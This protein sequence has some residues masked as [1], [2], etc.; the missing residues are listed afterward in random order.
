MPLMPEH[1]EPPAGLRNRTPRF[2]DP[3]VVRV[4]WP[5]ETELTLTQAGSRLGLKEPLDDLL[6]DW[7]ALRAL[8]S[9]PAPIIGVMGLLN[10]GKSSLVKQF[11]SPEGR[12]RVLCGTGSHQGTHRFV[13][14]LPKAWQDD[15][16]IMM[17]FREML[18]SA[19]G[20]QIEELS[21]DPER[22]AAQY[23]GNGD[24]AAS[25]GIP[26]IAFDPALDGYGFCLLDCADFERK[27]PGAPD[28][29]I[30]GIRVDFVRRASKL[31]SAVMVLGERS[32]AA[33]EVLLL[34][35]TKTQEEMDGKSTRTTA[36]LG[37]S[38]IPVFLLLNQLNFHEESPEQMLHDEEVKRL[39][40]RLGAQRIFVAY[41]GRLDRAR[42]VIP[43]IFLT[44]D[45]DPGLPCFF[46][47]AGDAGGNAPAAVAENRVLAHHLR[48]LRPAALWAARRKS[49]AAELA[50][51]LTRLDKRLRERLLEH[52][53]AL[54][55]KR[56][57]LIEFIRDQVRS[58]DNELAFPLLPE[59]VASITE[60]IAD[61]APWYAKPAMWASQ[62][63]KHTLEFTKSAR[64]LVGLGTRLSDPGKLVREGAE[65][66]K[67]NAART[68]LRSFEPVDWARR[69]R[70]QK[71]MPDEV[72]EHELT[73]SWT[74][75]RDAAMELKIE[76]DPKKTREFAALLWGQL[77]WSKKLIL[78]AT[79]PLLLIG[80]MASVLF[81]MFDGGSTTIFLFFSLKELLLA[82]G[83]G[84]AA[85]A[86]TVKG[87]ERLEAYLIERAGIP[88]YER[89]LRAALDV[90][91]LPLAGDHP[92]V[93]RFQ[94]TEEFEVDFSRPP[95]EGRLAPVVNLAAG[96]ILA[97]FSQAGWDQL[98]N[99]TRHTSAP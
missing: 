91:G 27:H 42:E 50:D 94:N 4:S 81:A 7:K 21:A 90:F 15:S 31:L 64:N 71:F 40:A 13:F 25:F 52:H 36:E 30:T 51:A 97:E 29:E 33:A 86:T 22:A 39:M 67:R 35:F 49:K 45:Y 61:T 9:A 69:S 6:A 17:A 66:F 10:A 76:L 37:L 77:S 74:A 41:H 5:D 73:R 65:N 3:V 88:F 48:Q 14:W 98:R 87:G 57:S 53:Q 2:P 89:L 58:R 43:H 68:D 46:E 18:E 95:G 62:G 26:L 20:N 24:I 55:A 56:E 32:K 23:N 99:A 59:A 11:L 16:A 63:V 78:A 80:A 12:S 83:L 47:P 84:G 96:R 85:V 38:G 82:L 8:A 54:S 60:A 70:N 93:E 44:P 72:S 79:G 34:P 92:L 1:P 28:F 19:F 75:V